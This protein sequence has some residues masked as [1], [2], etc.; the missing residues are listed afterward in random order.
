M[1]QLFHAEWLNVLIFVICKIDSQTRHNL[2]LSD[3]GLFLT[4]QPVG[5][6]TRTSMYWESYV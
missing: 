4:L 1:D 5:S 6:Y 2:F 3:L